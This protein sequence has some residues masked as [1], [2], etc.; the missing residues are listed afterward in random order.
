MNNQNQLRDAVYQFVLENG[1]LIPV[2]VARNFKLE[3]M[4]ASA[5]LSELV[6]NKKLNVTKFLKI[7]TS[8]LYYALGQEEKLSNFLSYLPQ[9]QR[10]IA[11]ILQENKILRDN[12]IEPWQRVA[13]REISDFA[14][15][16]K[17]MT[18]SGE[19][20]FW[21][22]YIFP[23]NE[24]I[25]IIN[26]ALTLKKQEQ[27]VNEPKNEVQT[28]ITPQVKGTRKIK[29]QEFEN[30]VLNYL[31]NNNLEANNK[32]TI[33]KNSDFEFESSMQTNLGNIH[34]YVKARKKTSINESDLGLA[35]NL[36][37]EKK[38]PIL[39]LTDGKLTKKAEKYLQ[40]NKLIL[41]RNIYG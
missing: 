14:F 39:F 38:I 15:P 35:L 36:S 29:S 24:A 16:L 9:R 7:G 37:N 30:D 3:I 21:H 2:Q 41:F 28:T 25:P 34:I 8:P 18:D 17:I 22:W 10:Q 31:T 33:R 1:P 40:Q 6:S 27:I 4:M 11:L 12:L 5:Y 26:K 20:I 23:E 13:L 32:K 19:E